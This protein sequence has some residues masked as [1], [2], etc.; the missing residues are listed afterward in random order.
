L[1]IE[2]WHGS[3]AAA[4]TAVG[5]AQAGAAVAAIA[6]AAGTVLSDA[7]PP[8]TC[9]PAHKASTHS[10]RLGITV[11]N[12]SRVNSP[13]ETSAPCARSTRRHNSVASEPV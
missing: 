3:G 11:E 12:P 4:G 2:A 7:N 9:R 10:A 6:A 13:N 5:V 8:T 1:L